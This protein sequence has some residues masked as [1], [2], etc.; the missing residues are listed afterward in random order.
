ML[1]LVW[2][3]NAF[4]LL[5][6]SYVLPGFEVTTLFAALAAAL[7]LGLANITIRPILLL[8]TLPINILTLG[9]FTFIINA[10][11]LELVANV[12][13]GFTIV[14]FRTA[15]LGALILAVISWITNTIFKSGPKAAAQA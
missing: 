7:L 9:L 4:A 6:V 5:V 14:D 11:M 8:L 13:E 3:L 10:L 1:L 15:L 2:L 12:V